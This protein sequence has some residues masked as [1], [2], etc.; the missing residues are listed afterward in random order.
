MA[1]ITRNYLAKKRAGY[2]KVFILYLFELEVLRAQGLLDF[3]IGSPGRRLHGAAEAIQHPFECELL[4]FSS[5]Y[6]LS[7]PATA[8]TR[9]RDVSTVTRTTDG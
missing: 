8:A 5:P 1:K 9:P 6:R 3:L 7:E 4:H 2:L